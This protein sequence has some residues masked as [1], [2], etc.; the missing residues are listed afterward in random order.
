M[1]LADGFSVCVC[2]LLG[3]MVLWLGSGVAVAQRL[4]IN[5]ADVSLV[6]ISGEESGQSHG[7]MVRA[8]KSGER[9]V[10]NVQQS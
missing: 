9:P 6:E 1:S 2:R 10:Q 8:K 3:L 7:P 5:D 4:R